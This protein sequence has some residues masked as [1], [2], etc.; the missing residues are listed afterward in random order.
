MKHFP[1]SVLVQAARASAPAKSNECSACFR[2]G[3]R[4]KPRPSGSMRLTN[5]FCTQC[6]MVKSPAAPPPFH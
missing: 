6:L 3:E 2:S 1:R 5:L 4:D